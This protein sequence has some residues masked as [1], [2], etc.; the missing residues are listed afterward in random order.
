MKNKK[1]QLLSI[2]LSACILGTSAPVNAADFYSDAFSADD[3]VEAEPSSEI[4]EDLSSEENSD[5]ADSTG[6]DTQEE[7]SEDLLQSPKDSNSGSTSD[8]SDASSLEEEFNAGNEE[9]TFSDSDGTDDFSSGEE[10]GVQAGILDGSAE[11]QMAKSSSVIEADIPVSNS[12]NTTCTIYKGS[13]LENQNYSVWSS[14][15]ESYLT[16]S[17]DGS[18]MRVQSGALDGKLLIEYYDSGYNFKKTMTLDLPLPVFGAFYET[19]DN[20]Y[21]LTGANNTEKDN[22]KEV[23]R[24][25]KYSKDWKSQGS[26][27]LFG[28]NTT[29]PFDA[30]SARMASYGNYLFIRTCHEMYGGHQANVTF[31]VD[32]STMSV[33]DQL[34]GIQN[35]E[36]GYVSHSFNQFIQIDNGT[37]LGCDH[38]DAYPRAITVL[39]YPTDISSGSFVPQYSWSSSSYACKEFDLMTFPGSSGNNYTG[40]SLGGFEYSDSSYLVAGNY[41]ADNHSRNVFVSSVSKSG[42][43][44]VV[45]Y[46]SDY[47]GTSDSAATPHL[48]KTGSNS[49]VLL[50]SSQG[51]VYYT[52]ID[53]TGQQAGS[54][55]KM[56]GNLSDCAPSVITVSYTHLTLP[57]ILRV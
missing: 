39:Q 10:G 7:S 52:A 15:V 40:A 23:Y 20:Y 34:T 16:T 36:F 42:G 54:T 43:T 9:E 28:A 32:T 48:V 25:S 45:R 51:Y 8:A 53:G 13:N 56:A 12:L 57:T 35:S 49:F 29:Y 38:G 50:W 3:N 2:F 17:P 37:L 46:F 47:A 4:S 55:Y 18:L 21:I 1:A 31:S 41:D 30:G 19:N 14:P 44:P 27:S 5:P 26:C 11:A 6:I 24:V 22:T 33:V